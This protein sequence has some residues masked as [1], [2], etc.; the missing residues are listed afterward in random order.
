LRTIQRRQR[1]ALRERQR[2]VCRP[3]VCVQPGPVL[4]ES[5]L[6]H[7]SGALACPRQ[8]HELHAFAVAAT[9]G[10]YQSH[11]RV[12]HLRQPSQRARQNRGREK[13]DCSIPIRFFVRTS[14]SAKPAVASFKPPTPWAFS[15]SVPFFCPSTSSLGEGNTRGVQSVCRKR[16][17]RAAA[18]QL[19][20]SA[21]LRT[22]WY[23]RS[24]SA[25]VI[26]RSRRGWCAIPLQR[27]GIQAPPP[28]R[29]TTK[30]SGAASGVAVD[31]A[32][33]QT[34][35]DIKRKRAHKF[36]LYH[37]GAQSKQ[38]PP[39]LGPGWERWQAEPFTSRAASF[40][41]SCYAGSHGRVFSGTG[42]STRSRGRESGDQEQ[43]SRLGGGGCPS[44]AALPALTPPCCVLLVPRADATTMK[45][46]IVHKSSPTVRATA[47]STPILG[48]QSPASTKSSPHCTQPRSGRTDSCTQ[49]DGPL[50]ACH[51]RVCQLRGARMHVLTEAP[52]V[53]TGVLRGV[54]RAA[55]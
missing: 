20:G 3:Q 43:A 35:L 47:H 21:S 34:Y 49:A 23:A 39:A 8:E 42:G 2:H 41:L 10:A 25:V 1:R 26:L 37:I 33:V 19:E 24:T 38:P 44:G 16:D 12:L 30:M 51:P 6:G 50:R 52:H 18:H 32:C 36:V 17:S 53:G 4:G 46:V 28:R 29:E 55:A 14:S 5:C 45:I 48:A 22:A 11:P 7:H 31:D 13:S 27:G 9:V 54:H 15:T 40:R